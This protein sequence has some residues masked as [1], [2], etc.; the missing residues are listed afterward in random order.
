[1]KDFSNKPHRM[2][3]F[4]AQLLIGT[5]ILRIIRVNSSLYSNEFLYKNP[6]GPAMNYIKSNF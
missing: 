3:S 4:K 2:I 5:G 6:D 1:M